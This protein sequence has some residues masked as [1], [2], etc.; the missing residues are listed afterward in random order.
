MKIDSYNYNKA[1]ELELNNGIKILISYDT[2][3]AAKIRGKS[4]INEEYYNYSKSTNNHL[5]W[6]FNKENAIKK[7]KSFFDNLL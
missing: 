4:Y 5:W 7:P 6:F 3:V 2:V 1:K